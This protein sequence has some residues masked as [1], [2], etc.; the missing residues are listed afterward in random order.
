MD[1]LLKLDRLRKLN[2]AIRKL[3]RIAREE[4]RQQKLSKN[5]QSQQKVADAG[6]ERLQGEQRRNREATDELKA[7]VRRLVDASSAAPGALVK[8]SESM[9]NAESGLQGKNAGEA[10]DQQAQAVDELAQA[11]RALEAERDQLL[12]ELRNQVRTMVT[13]A[14]AEM[15]DTQIRIRQSTQALGAKVEGGDRQ[16]V[17]GIKR[18]RG[19]QQLLADMA[20]QTIGLIEETE[21]SIAL[22][23]ALQDV[24]Q[25]M[26]AVALE[27]EAGNAA[28]EVVAAEQ[29][30]EKDLT[31]LLEAMKQQASQ[32]GP[33]GHGGG[34]CRA[35]KTRVTLIAELK[36]VRMLQLKVNRST[37]DV[38]PRRAAAGK[39]LGVQLKNVILDI[40]QRQSDLHDVTNRLH[41]QTCAE[42]AKLQS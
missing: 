27:L 7:N 24:E 8:A 11:R 25:Q 42:C 18:L 32:A 35:C 28:G 40:G 38:D 4:V 21:L 31:D 20:R 15:L 23:L 41:G 29:Q 26:V 17:L 34:N 30:I 3:D 9:L 5:L 1:L 10:A 39:E 2:E 13:Q 12:D 16:A 19:Q 37:H 36:M 14:L 6:F 22:P 33:G